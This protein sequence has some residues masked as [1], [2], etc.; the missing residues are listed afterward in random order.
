MTLRSL[1]AAGALVT[2]GMLVGRVLG[3]L[4]EMLLAWG[5]GASR[6]ADTAIVL[7]MI[8]DFITGA[9]LAGA[10]SA[11]LVPAFAA[12]T[13]KDALSLMWQVMAVSTAALAIVAALVFA[14]DW[15]SGYALSGGLPAWVFLVFLLALP[16]TAATAIAA[17]WL[18]HKSRFG[19]VAFAT[20]IFNAVIMASLVFMPTSLQVLAIAIMAAAC[21][22]LLAHIVAFARAEGGIQTPVLTPWQMDKTLLSH[23]LATATTGLL[24]MI[25]HYAPYFIMVA[26]GGGV[27]VFNYAFKLILMPAML[28]QGVIQMVLLPWLVQRRKLAGDGD[29]THEMLLF[30]WTLAL[31]MCLSLSRAGYDIAGLCFGYGKMTFVDVMQVGRTF[32]FGVWALMGMLLTSVWQQVMYA[33]GNTRAPLQS[34]LLLAVIVL[35]ACWLGHKILGLEGVALMYAIIQL[36]PLLQLA[37]AGKKHGLITKLSPSLEYFKI[38]AAVVI[39]WLPLAWLHLFLAFSGT[40]SA[41]GGLILCM[42]IGMVLLLAGVAA[43]S[44]MRRRFIRS[45]KLA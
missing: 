45:K 37:R 4:R 36:V 8:P 40:L 21:V 9:L 15:A 26:A 32:S 41:I 43:S 25:P 2:T 7:L 20:A 38:S 12:R 22:R 11:T 18:Q 28:G 30:V 23:Y 17:A 34:N 39:V 31:A 24:A 44:T 3:L 6:E 14:G 19:V 16:L 33:Q 10:A 5:F 29:Q 13:P 1:F 27:A 42:G 35:P